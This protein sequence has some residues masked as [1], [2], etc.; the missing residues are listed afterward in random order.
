M[1]ATGPVVV[2]DMPQVVDVNPMSEHDL[3]L[4]ILVSNSGGV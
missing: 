3:Y 2:R 1:F 4:A